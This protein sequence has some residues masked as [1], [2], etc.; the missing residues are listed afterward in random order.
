MFIYSSNG[1]NERSGNMIEVSKMNAQREEMYE[2]MRNIPDEYVE[3]VLK[4][5][6]LLIE[7]TESEMGKYWEENIDTLEPDN[8]VI[9]PEDIEALKNMEFK[10]WDDI[11]DRI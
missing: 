1:K 10:N 3:K 6:N 11:K 8:I 5:I 4:L 9:T 7:P 2:M